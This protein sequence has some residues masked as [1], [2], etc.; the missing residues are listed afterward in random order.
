[1]STSTMQA[2]NSNLLHTRFNL[3][4]L[5]FTLS[6]GFVLLAIVDVRRGF[7]FNALNG[8]G[9]YFSKSPYHSLSI[10]DL[11]IFVIGA[12][13]LLVFY[14][15][16]KYQEKK[17][18]YLDFERYV[19]I[20]A[21]AIFSILVVDMFTY[22]GVAAAR[23][24]ANGTITAGW[25]D[26]WGATG[27]L[28]PIALAASYILTVWH[29][30][31]LGVLFA[32]LSLTILPR[33]LASFY[34]KT[35]FGGNLFGAT[36]ALPQPFCSCCASV[37]A[38]SLEKHGAS[39]NF[40]LSFV[41][42]SP[43]LNI[44]GLILAATLL[45]APYAITRILGGILLTIP[46]T[47]GIAKAADRW[48]L[49]EGPNVENWFT[50]FTAKLAGAYCKLFHLDEMVEGRKMGTPTEFI[51]TYAQTTWRLALLL[52]PTLFIWS[53]V[54]AGFFQLLPSGFG[55]NLISILVTAVAGTF[56]MI[57]TWTE[58]PVAMQMINAGFSAPAATVLLVLPPVSLPCLMILG[59]AIGKFRVVALLS[60]A[61]ILI[62]AV[63]GVLFI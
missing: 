10:F 50:R 40:M 45:P 44:T 29:A 12:L 26:A 11:I 53:I 60:V 37:I 61:V 1:M 47:Y 28:Q 59:G 43:M 46:V 22:R 15:Q 34:T 30:T 38:P 56:L 5:G 42:G 14:N 63:A 51:G 23:I 27:W 58:I 20:L 49:A 35:G 55:N 18:T 21:F 36:Y 6:V 8:F 2:K 7:L 41:V 33:Y 13:G 4:L 3:T 24:V 16:L 19:K 31:L 48:D 54:A 52:I 32:G 17:L 25:L 39:R 9:E 62:G 57:S